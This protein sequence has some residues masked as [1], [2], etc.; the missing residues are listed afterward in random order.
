M[1]IY[2]IVPNSIWEPTTFAILKFAIEDKDGGIYG[3]SPE[4][5]DFQGSK[6]VAYKYCRHGCL[7]YDCVMDINNRQFLECHLVLE[8]IKSNCYYYY[9]YHDRKVFAKTD[10]LYQRVLSSLKYDGKPILKAKSPEDIKLNNVIAGEIPEGYE[11]L[12]KAIFEN[13]NEI[14]KIP[15]TIK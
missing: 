11:D 12:Y 6:G 4:I 13:S 9:Y 7:V 8:G 1:S 14:K 3:F 10:D 2:R 5:D 15:E